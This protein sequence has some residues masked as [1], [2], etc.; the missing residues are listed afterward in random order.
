MPFYLTDLTSGVFLIR[1]KIAKP[2]AALKSFRTLEMEMWFV[3]DE[4]TPLGRLH[5]CGEARHRG[6]PADAM[7]TLGCYG[8]IYLLEGAGEFRDANRLAQNV[9]AG[10]VLLLFPDVP[11]AYGPPEGAVWRELFLHFDGAIFDAL[12]A[13]GVLHPSRPIHRATPQDVW[14]P[15][16][17]HLARTP[18]LE[19]VGAGLKL[20]DLARLLAQIVGAPSPISPPYDWLRHACDLLEGDINEHCDLPKIARLVGLSYSAFRQKFKRATGV[21]PAQWRARHRVQSACRLL[22]TT[23]MSHRAIARTLG[24]ADE[25]QFSRRFSLIMGTS[26]R[27]WRRENRTAT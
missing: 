11:H 3:E 12:R 27:Q 23:E 4:P 22:E 18:R 5:F 16:F 19:T 7:R 15:Q 13:C 9:S 20:L 8:A 14:L 1:M 6:I 21:S 10:D 17:R 2:A 25:A 26:P 24:Y